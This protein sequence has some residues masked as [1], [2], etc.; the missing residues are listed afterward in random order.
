MSPVNEEAGSWPCR[1]LFL[2]DF[3]SR[4]PDTPDL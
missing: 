3:R 1:L 2:F 4:S